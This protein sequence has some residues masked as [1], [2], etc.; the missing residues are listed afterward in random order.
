M[1]TIGKPYSIFKRNRVYYCRFKLPDGNWSTARSTGETSKG[2]AERWAIDYLQAGKGQIAVNISTTLE[3]LSKD[4][5]SWSGQWATDKRVRGLRLSPHHCHQLNN[6]I[7][8]H[9]L[10]FMGNKRLSNI[11]RAVIRDFRNSLFKKGY[12]GNTINKILS[13]LKMLLEA[14]ED[15]AL[16]QYVPKIERAAL[17]PKHK[18][19]LTIEEVKKLFSIQWMSEAAHCHPSKNQFIGYAGNLLACSTG[20][21]MGEIQGLVL[22]DI[23]LDDGYIYVRRSWDKLFGLNETTKTGRARN[24]F[25]PDTVKA[26]LSQLIKL[27][28]EPGNPESFV[29]FAELK[30]GKPVESRVF[31]RSLYA[32][33]RAI[34]IS[35][36]ERRERNITFHSWRHWFNSLLINAKVPLQK[37]QSLTGHLTVEMT[38][39]YYHLDELSDVVQVVEDTLFTNPDHNTSKD[40]N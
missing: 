31:T 40:V 17:N 1:S 5:F 19:I 12:S 26:V 27:N 16:I 22:S 30:P 21:R 3:T 13:A 33:L 37:I 35:E 7:K 2:R 4:F 6:L 38:Q 24:I 14:A 25:I 34:G 29:F 8:G 28:P 23:H 9:I 39:H 20:L 15:Q 32:A 18:G 36:Q 10:P 11:D